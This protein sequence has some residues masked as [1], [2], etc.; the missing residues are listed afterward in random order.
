MDLVGP[1]NGDLRVG[2]Y[3]DWLSRAR[4][5]GV[6]EVPVPI[7]SLFRRRHEKNT[8]RIRR[9]DYSTDVFKII[10]E[11]RSRITPSIN[12]SLVDRNVKE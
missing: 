1:L 8:S 10:H 11:H 12:Q 6:K 9:K 4:D 7:V 5:F 3:V 2:E